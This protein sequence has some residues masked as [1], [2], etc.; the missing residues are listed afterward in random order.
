MI[1]LS[2]AFGM[3]FAGGSV[4]LALSIASTG[5]DACTVVQWDFSYLNL[6]L[7]S[8]MAGTAAAGKS[9]SRTGNQ[10]I[11]GGFDTNV[12]PDGV[13]VNATFNIAAHPTANPI[14][15]ALTALAASDADANPLTTASS[16]GSIGYSAPF[17][18]PGLTFNL[19]T[20]EI[21]RHADTDRNLLRHLRSH[22]LIR[23]HGPNYLL[24]QYRRSQRGVYRA[25]APDAARS[26]PSRGLD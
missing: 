12:I 7:A 5:G 13:L 20:G 2:L 15:I 4:T 19:S 17:P 25:I 10:I 9:L 11:I 24:H 23:R 26:R 6:T 22:G 14:P 16:P 8:V 21:S 18:I 3:G 1:T